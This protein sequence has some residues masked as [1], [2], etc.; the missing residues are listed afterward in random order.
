MD[1]Q[2]IKNAYFRFLID[3]IGIDQSY[4]DICL[5]LLN[6][7]FIPI[8]DMD[9]NR[10]GDCLSLRDEFSI[11]NPDSE[12]IKTILG[13]EYGAYGAMLELVIILSQKMQYELIDSPY[14]APLSKWF[15]EILLNAGIGSV[16]DDY[17]ID[18][19]LQ[20]VILRQ[21]DWDG[22]GGFFPL[23]QLDCGDQRY[24]ELLIQMNNYIQENYDIV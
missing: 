16:T 8:V 11:M 15:I 18:V 2:V 9:E 23:H 3:K 17:E 6:T 24:E 10:C 1:R 12:E 5:K 19:I 20:T 14:D 4:D 13:D 22:V 7:P 21:Y